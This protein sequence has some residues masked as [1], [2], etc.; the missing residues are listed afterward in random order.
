[1]LVRRRKLERT[2]SRALAFDGAPLR[3][4]P[5]V[6]RGGSS[7]FFRDIYDVDH[8]EQR[9]GGRFR[10]LLSTCLAAT[11]GAIAILVVVYG[12]SDKSGMDDRLL[13]EFSN[14]LDGTGMRPIF[15]AFKN[16]DGLKW[17]LPKT[18]RL[19]L[20]TGALS[21]RYIIH[22][23]S[24]QRRDG[25]EYMRQKPYARIVARLAPVS[26]NY[27]DVI[28]PFNPFKLYASSQPV[29]AGGDS[30][31]NSG[32]GLSRSDI[33]VKVV[34]LLG[35]IL[36]GEDGE[37]L[38][39]R[40]VQDLVERAGENASAGN[41]AAAAADASGLPLD[42]VA[43]ATDEDIAVQGGQPALGPEANA[44][45]EQ[46]PNTTSIT[47]TAETF[48]E[49]D[50][51][52][53]AGEVS[54]VKVGRDDTLQTIL[55]RAGADDWQ[56]RAMIDAARAT[57]PESALV[58]GQEVRI[59]LVPS[60]TQANKKEPSS[61]S[62]FSDGHD[63][64]VTVSRSAAGE[65]VASTLPSIGKELQSASSD[66][67][68]AQ[69]VS[70]YAS[71]YHAAL[72]QNIEPDTI[73]SVLRIH[74]FDT[75]FRRRVRPG[76]T[77]EMFFDMKDEQS[78]DGP[79]GELLY[80]AINSG[81]A[82]ARFYRFRT[83]DGHVDY[84]DDNG[85]N[86]KKFLMRKPVRGDNVRLTSGFGVRYH[87]LLNTRKMH[88]GVDW[89]TAPG[90]P[91]LASGNGTIEEAGHKGYYGN[92]IRI[93]HANGYH[94]AYGHMMRLAAGVAEGVKVRQGQVIGYVG[95]T[96]L[97]SGPHLHFEVLVNSRF[98]DPMSIQVP[99]ERKLEGK[100]LADF[101]KERTH[102]D[103]LMKRSPVMT[104]SK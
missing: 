54:V 19:Q 74:A 78:T 61:F 39:T 5:E 64:L 58:P 75:D 6:Y 83:P 20:T 85:N 84:Y 31:D 25:R 56:A 33:S 66:G 37:E 23:S 41:D 60:L 8:V 14:I 80:T 35:G 92:Y 95:S 88:T 1:M 53:E 70:L 49:V 50:N 101:Q 16:A 30:D 79:P 17:L 27:A 97:S 12:S 81:G 15:P 24:K 47:K 93:R 43:A 7:S 99:R 94:T 26:G 11:V 59:T 77:V 90:T 86:S 38:D 76:D 28:P 32:S 57:F 69:A 48:E 63:H 91:I 52:L 65:F 98:V 22:E 62:V 40:E 42:G 29:N 68:N 13:P 96:G 100:D 55:Q 67:E 87:P 10:W 2:H 44:A 21:T 9:Q 72:V 4:I 18:D 71:F 104:A 89:A 45:G 51:D 82:V 3:G 102:I 103:D 46:L 73:M 34:E 36:P